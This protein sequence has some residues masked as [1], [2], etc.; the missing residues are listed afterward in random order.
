MLLPITLWTLN[1]ALHQA[2]EIRKHFSRFRI[3]V[4]LSANLLDD[5]D[6]VEIVSQALQTWDTDPQYLV[7]EITESAMM[8]NPDACM[9]NL[10]KLNQIGVHLSID[11]FG[12]G[13]SS[14]SYLKRMPVQELKIDQS[15]IRN[16]LDD[17]NDAQIVQAIVNLG[18]QFKL[19]VVAEGIE[20][21][22][23]MDRL[24]EMGCEYGQGY[25]IA[26][27]LDFKQMLRW[28]DESEWNST[29]QNRGLQSKGA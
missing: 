9:K 3:A 13:Y 29:G 22:A 16:I 24:I 21:S 20:S 18:R 15:F 23:V 2:T 5:P 25:L 27:P 11:D 28:V 7:L 26:R 17:N 4:N 14:F 10:L 1:T 6:L 12:T 19:R 8:R